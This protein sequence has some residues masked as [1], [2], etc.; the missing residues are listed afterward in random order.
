MRA[1]LATL[2]IVGIVAALGGVKAR[3]IGMLMAFGE[4][5]QQAGPP[6]EVV[7]AAV[8]SEQTWEKTLVAIAS[9]VS[10]KGVAVSNDAAGR[11]TAVRFESGDAVKRG[12]VLVEL[13][14]KVERAQLASLRARQKLAE[15][16]L[17][18]TRALAAQGVIAQAE[19]DNDEA[20]HKSLSADVATIEA[21]IARKV[22]RAPFSG[23]LGIR[24]VN[25]GQYLAPGTQVTSLESAESAFVDLSLP[26][27]HLDEVKLGMV[28]RTYEEGG[29]APL[30]EG[31]IS[32][33]E[34]ALD[35]QTRNIK[36]RASL[37]EGAHPL[38]PGMFLRV[39]VVLPERQQV[40]AIPVTA[41]VHA[42]FGDSVFVVE[43]KPGPDGKP[44]PQARQQFVKL[45]RTR[46]AFV[47]VLAGLAAGA[48]VVTAGAFKLRNGLP[49]KI[50]NSVG[51][52]PELAPRAENR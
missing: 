7:S 37:P 41:V 1:L 45:G 21:Q 6:P 13:D 46:G 50:D 42:S 9:V 18:R 29:S 52:K 33:I 32:A 38:R 10:A 20:T 26:Q 19:L 15:T 17:A 51:K 3:Q 25:L 2:G 4:Q 31:T 40:I 36:V 23:K 35:A 30:A 8:A 49:L 27:R 47:S 28:V 39:E 44:R 11:V 12:Q 16:E 14:T 24:E 34:P 43:E 22:I 5:M 48:Q